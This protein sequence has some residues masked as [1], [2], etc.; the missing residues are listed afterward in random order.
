MKTFFIIL[1]I[2][3]LSLLAQSP[4]MA[5][6]KTSAYPVMNMYDLSG[7]L[8]PTNISTY[9]EGFP[10]VTEFFNK[11]V[12]QFSNGVQSTGLFI[13]YNLFDNTLRFKKDS[14]EYI[15]MD[16]VSGFILTDD[17]AVRYEFKN[18]FPSVEKK[19][20]ATF[21]QV[22]SQGRNIQLLKYIS[23]N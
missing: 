15:M 6:D 23:K 11:G 8:I 22:L 1:A 7:K 20:A 21:Y 12:V 5:T 17:K 2:A 19:T 10:Y 14:N 9:A 16:A 4:L 3:P 18:N 13:N